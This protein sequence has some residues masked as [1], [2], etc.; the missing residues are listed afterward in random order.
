MPIAAL[1]RDVNGEY[2]IQEVSG[3]PKTNL[4]DWFAMIIAVLSGPDAQG[5]EAILNQLINVGSDLDTD[6]VPCKVDPVTHDYYYTYAYFKSE[7]PAKRAWHDAYYIGKGRRNR[8]L[9]HV[10][11]VVTHLENKRPLRNT[12]EKSIADWLFQRNINMGAID[13][14]I[15]A[16]KGAIVQRLY[17]T[18]N[19]DALA[20]AMAFFTE[21]FLI[22]RA[23]DAQDFSN[24]TAGNRKAGA[25]NGLV[26][27]K[28]F[29][30]NNPSHNFLWKKAITAFFD[31]PNQE[32]IN[33]TYR[34]AMRFISAGP[35]IESMD[36]AMKRIKLE[37][38]GMR[39]ATENRIRPQ[40][41]HNCMHHDHVS[42]SGAADSILS[43]YYPKN[44]IF[45]FDF[46]LQPGGVETN[47]TLRPI[48]SNRH[49][50]LAFI[51]FMDNLTLV[52]VQVGQLCS[53]EL[54]VLTHYESLNTAFV[55]NRNNW[56]FCKPIT[57]GADGNT[58][59]WHNIL[60]PQARRTCLVD[61]IQGPQQTKQVEIS[62]LEAVELTARA[63]RLIPPDN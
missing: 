22:T 33:H 13:Q 7:K 38:F 30:I 16:A 40:K 56:P 58:A 11:T 60:D 19:N 2:N 44:Q 6:E 41:C 39:M 45:R 49:D 47:I 55:K 53:L 52:P 23:R 28:A 18:N 3:L 34:P 59:C 20:E 29:N 25:Y 32:A 5:V 1:M 62:L 61:W 27:P 46:R 10:S 57:L 37:P 12:K 21:Y 8:W 42:V 31:N 43:Y 36:R 63:F 51:D 35:L 9:E 4:E 17:E 24:N 50:K 15:Q 26:K 48:S 14:A 54:N